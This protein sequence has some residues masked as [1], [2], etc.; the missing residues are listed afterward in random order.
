MLRLRAMWLAGVAVFAG[1]LL[2]APAATQQAPA[3]R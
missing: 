2:A 1:L 3:T